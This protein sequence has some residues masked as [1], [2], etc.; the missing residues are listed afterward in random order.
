LQVEND[1]RTKEPAKK[2]RKP[3]IRTGYINAL[4]YRY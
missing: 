1:Y 3:F 4:D 2:T